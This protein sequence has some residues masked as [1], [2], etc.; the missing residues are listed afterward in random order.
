MGSGNQAGRARQA[1]RAGVVGLEAL[2]R[3]QRTCRVPCLFEPARHHE[4]VEGLRL[5]IRRSGGCRLSKSWRNRYED[6]DGGP[7][8]LHLPILS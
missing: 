1:G 7:S 8:K 6:A 5:R 4:F 2:E 3:S